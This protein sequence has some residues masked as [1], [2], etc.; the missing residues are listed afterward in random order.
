[1]QELTSND[2]IDKPQQTVFKKLI[3]PVDEFVAGQNNS[4]CKK[5]GDE[6][7]SSYKL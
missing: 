4:C 7:I 2:C 3:E 1:M 5:T 6:A